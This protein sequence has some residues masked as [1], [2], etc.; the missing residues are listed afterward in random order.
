MALSENAIVTTGSRRERKAHGSNGFPCAGYER[1]LRALPGDIMT[2]HWHQ[3]M[4]A[5][6]MREGSVQLLLLSRKIE[7]KQGD[8]ALINANALHSARSENHGVL[9]ICVFSPLLIEGNR[10]S[11]IAVNYVEP[12]INDPEFSGNRLSLSEELI[13]QYDQAFQNLKYDRPGYEIA[14]RNALSSIVFAAYEEYE[15]GHEKRNGYPDRDK[16]RV[17]DM[18]GY[19]HEHYREDISLKE[20]SESAHIGNRE[21]QRCFQ[22]T[23]GESP[24][25]YLMKYRLMNSADELVHHPE[26][27]I[28]VTAIRCGFSSPSYFTEKFHEF[29]LCTPK[30]FIHGNRKE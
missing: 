20:I 13:H 6:Y 3:E 15:S 9:E 27:S 22:R 18:L 25:Q 8:F 24:M 17:T 19:I 23:I 5:M 1:E 30:E 29:Y 4:E 21:A 2:W 7:L 16:K 12:L 28:A 26:Q 11:A 10:K 14:V